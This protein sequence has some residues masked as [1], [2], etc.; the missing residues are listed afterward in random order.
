MRKVFVTGSY[1]DLRSR[2]VRFLEEASRFGELHV[3]LWPD[4][5]ICDWEGKPPKFPLAERIYLLQA[6]RYV[7]RVSVC[8][9]PVE[10][11]ALPYP[12][13]IKP[14][15]W[16]VDEA[17][18]NH[19]KKAYC[20]S[21][22]IGYQAIKDADL[23]GWPI[24]Q[25]DSLRELSGRKKV[26]VT[27]SFDWLHSG[28][29]RF[30]EEVSQLGDLYVGVG[31]DG[32]IQLLKGPGHPMHSQNERC[33]M[34]QAVRYVKHALITSGNGWMDAEPEIEMIK[35]DIYVVN[36]D[37]DVPEKRAYCDKLGMKYIVLKRSP[38]EGLPRR[39][40][41]ALRGF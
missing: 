13:G 19:Q 15:L 16:I 38:K 34:V 20:A 39:E 5:V 7:S 24:Q 26:I 32:N 40:S 36:E 12:D 29:V 37:G 9:M 33:Y 1:D 2:Q 30:L 10:R 35:P 11:E 41:T 14:D 4:E 28:H 27:G 21:Y 23:R 18:D 31:H 22:G 25:F 6:I 8:Q 3:M 17:S